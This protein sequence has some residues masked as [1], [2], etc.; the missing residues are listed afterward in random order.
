[1][2]GSRERIS[3]RRSSGIA[4]L[5]SVAAVEPRAVKGWADAS[6]SREKERRAALR[7]SGG[8][9]AAARLAVRRGRP[10]KQGS[11]AAGEDS[12]AVRGAGGSLMWRTADPT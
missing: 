8:V 9:E 6:G 4:A 2:A 7:E 11:E 10:W 5:A 1:M 12:A 3:T